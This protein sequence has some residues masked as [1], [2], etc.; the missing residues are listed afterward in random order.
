MC[1]MYRLC[2]T[3]ASLYI[4]IHTNTQ[5]SN[6]SRGIAVQSVVKLLKYKSTKKTSFEIK[7]KR[8]EKMMRQNI[9]SG[10]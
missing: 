2:T 8:K 6:M 3:K 9:N 4:K 1:L 7:K 5:V 10:N